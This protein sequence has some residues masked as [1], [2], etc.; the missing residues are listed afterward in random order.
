ME[1]FM[2]QEDFMSSR[3]ER[4][5]YPF[6]NLLMETEFLLWMNLKPLY[7]LNDN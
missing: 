2:A 7:L 6:S 3:M 5:F 1:V 4:V